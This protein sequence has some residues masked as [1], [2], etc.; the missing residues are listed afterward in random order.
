M[1]EI[2]GAIRPLLPI[3][4]FIILMCSV[5]LL[6]TKVNAILRNYVPARHRATVHRCFLGFLAY[7]I[8]ASIYQV[9]TS[10]VRIAE[11]LL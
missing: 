2:I 11:K 8:L 5:I 4:C 7:A 9:L 3:A 1:I 6:V 10:Y